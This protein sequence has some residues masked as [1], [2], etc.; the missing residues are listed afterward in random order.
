MEQYLPGRVQSDASGRRQVFLGVVL[1][2][3]IAG[4]ASVSG[5]MGGGSTS[6]RSVD[7]GCRADGGKAA[8]PPDLC[9]MFLERLGAAYPNHRFVAAPAGAQP[10]A[11]LVVGRAGASRLEARLD[12]HGGTKSV[13]GEPLGTAIADRTLGAEEYGRFLDALIVATPMPDDLSH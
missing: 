10:M 2:V 7:V 6:A 13:A 9:T 12:W 1:A 4:G 8:V 3:S 5:A 11:E